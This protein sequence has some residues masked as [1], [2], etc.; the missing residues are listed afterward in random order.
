MESEIGKSKIIKLEDGRQIT[1]TVEDDG[2]KIEMKNVSG[3][4]S[5]MDVE[6]D[7]NGEPHGVLTDGEIKIK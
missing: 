4:P 5:G 3:N 2:I 7:H 1:L 6:Y